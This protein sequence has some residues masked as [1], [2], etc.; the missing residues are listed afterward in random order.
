MSWTSLDKYTRTWRTKTGMESYTTVIAVTI[1]TPLC[2]N[3]RIHGHNSTCKASPNIGEKE[4]YGTMDEQ[5][6]RKGIEQIYNSTKHY[7]SYRNTYNKFKRNTMLSYYSDKCTEYKRDTKRLWQVINNVIGKRK[8][9]GS[10]IPSITID[11]I[12]IYETKAMANKFGRYYAN[13]GGDLV[14][15]IPNSD[16]SIDNYLSNILR[17]LRS[18]VI[19]YTSIGE[20]ERIIEQLPN[21]NSSSHDKISNNALKALKTALSY[22]LMVI[23]NQSLT[24][25]QF[26][27]L[28]KLVEIVPLYKGKEEDNG[29]NYHPISLLMTLSKISEKIMY[30]CMYKFLTKENIFYDSQYRFCSKGSC[31]HAIAKMVGRLLQAKNKNLVQL[32]CILGFIKGIW[33]TWS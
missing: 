22:L 17:T 23:F 9:T 7:K 3:Q 20:I 6:L 16:I 26:P 31:E 33:Y 8:H 24:T 11:R 28:M 21:K 2:Y 5:G 30:T 32:W 13:M 25:G 15:K 12:E 19:W 1:S 4:I 27:E 10:V 14:S 29:I 18:L